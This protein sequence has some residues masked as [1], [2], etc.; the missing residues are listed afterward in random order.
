M[1]LLI[2]IYYFKSFLSINDIQI[3][4]TP[5]TDR[6]FQSEGPLKLQDIYNEVFSLEKAQVEV[7]RQDLLNR[8][9]TFGGGCLLAAVLLYLPPQL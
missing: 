4:L 6:Y 3:L 8:Y 7:L 2:Y 9:H 5:L 1:L